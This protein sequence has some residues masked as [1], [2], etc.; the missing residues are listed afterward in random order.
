MV[1]KW[2][3]VVMTAALLMCG[4]G[5]LPCAAAPGLSSL[6]AVVYEPTTGTVVYEKD[7]Y[8]PRPMA[9]TT[10][11]MTALLAAES[12]DLSRD[13]TVTAEAV[14]VEGSALGLRAGDRISMRDL[15]TGLLLSSGNDA[16]NTIALAVDG[17]LEKFAERMNRR[18]AAIGMTHS[19]F[20]TPSG[21]D[22][23]GHA[24]CAYDMALLGAEVLRNPT[25]AAICASKTATI[26]MGNPKRTVTI[27]NHNRL[28][29]LYADAIGMKTGFTKK[30]GR[31][32]VSAAR[33][34]GVTLIV[35]TLNGGDYWNDHMALYEYA[36]PKWQSVTPELPELPSLP[37]AGGVSPHIGLTAKQPEAL[38]LPAEKQL[39]TTV[40]LPRFLL[41]P[42]L[43][44]ETVGEI[45]WSLDGQVVCRVPI[46][47]AYAVEARPVAGYGERWR[48]AWTALW[49]ALFG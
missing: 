16:A 23:E 13:I 21:L 11:L 41:A 48:R 17:S 30:S 15:I 6:S 27:A 7:A 32:L 37:V 18:A 20:V 33:R 5:N 3:A 47:T 2:L 42:L 29:S 31:C 25:L 44:G 34:N 35:V 22:A 49:M 8:T 40:E 38:T 45:C 12:G 9:S 28:L 36:F 24:A 10:K 26:Q 46:K 19:C 14:A 1:R 4:A 39:Q 43:A